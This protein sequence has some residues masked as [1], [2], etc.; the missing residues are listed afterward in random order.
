MS[1]RHR[2]DYQDFA[3]GAGAHPGTAVSDRVLTRVRMDLNPSPFRVFSKL[4]AVH[5]L[6]AVVTLSLCPQFGFRLFWDGMGLMHYF[7]AL[8]PYGCFVACGSFFTGMSLL[9]ACL[10]LRGE[11]IRKIRQNRWLELG[12]LTLVSLGFFVMV[13]AEVIFGI[14]VAWLVGALVGSVLSLELGWMLRF[15]APQ[16]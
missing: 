4:L 5:A 11:E 8:G 2:K 12:A 6:T 13:S 3:A 15:R 14:A 9:I 16:R 7:M 1:S 10:V